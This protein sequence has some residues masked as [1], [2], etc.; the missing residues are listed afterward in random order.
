MNKRK[1]LQIMP[2]IGWHATYQ[3]DQGIIKTPLVCWALIEED[4]NGELYTNVVGMDA[5]GHIDFSDDSS[6][7]LGYEKE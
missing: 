6:N 2:A 1:I 3:G 5:Q 7:F 4:E